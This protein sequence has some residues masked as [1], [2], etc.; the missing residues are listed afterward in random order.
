MFVVYHGDVYIWIVGL[1][2]CV[3]HPHCWFHCLSLRNSK[4]LVMWPWPSLFLIFWGVPGGGLYLNV[5]LWG[6]VGTNWFSCTDNFTEKN[7]FFNKYVAFIWV[8]VL[9]VFC[10]LGHM[11]V[12]WDPYEFRGGGYF[13]LNSCVCVY[14]SSLKEGYGF[15]KFWL[16]YLLK[17][18]QLVHFVCIYLNPNKYGTD[19]IF[20]LPENLSG[21]S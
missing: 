11:C 20:M 9:C 6:G 1:W 12:I 13:A 16:N 8:C 5:N 17:T 7:E 19:L 10:I 3:I 18:F 4:N 21:L 14:F 2:R 15:K